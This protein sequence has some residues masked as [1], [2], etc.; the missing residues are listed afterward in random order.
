MVLKR[1]GRSEVN[2]ALESTVT[3]QPFDRPAEISLMDPRDKLSTGAHFAAESQT[4]KAMQHRKHAVLPHAKHHGR[5]HGDFAGAGRLHL[6]RV[7]S[8][9]RATSTE[10]ASLASGVAPISPLSSHGPSNVCL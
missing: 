1:I 2:G 10:K 3:N 5:A 4:D 8:Q 7:P 9:A 6:R